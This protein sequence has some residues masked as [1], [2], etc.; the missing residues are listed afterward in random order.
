MTKVSYSIDLD[1]QKV[2]KCEAIKGA[3]G[4]DKAIFYVHKLLLFWGLRLI[5]Y[6]VNKIHY[7]RPLIQFDSDKPIKTFNLEET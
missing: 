7:S 2:Q 3:P 4:H 6:Y 5:E 1:S